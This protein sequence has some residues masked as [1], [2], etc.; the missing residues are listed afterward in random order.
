MTELDKYIKQLESRK[1]HLEKKVRDATTSSNFHVVNESKFISQWVNERINKSL[2]VITGDKPA[3][4]EDYLHAHA[5]VAVLRDF[6]KMLQDES[7]NINTYTEELRI[8]NEQLQSSKQA[9]QQ[10][11]Q[12]AQ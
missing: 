1:K 5:E 10:S 9:L 11:Q 8:I 3:E 6:N 2:K 12:P 7:G 4:R